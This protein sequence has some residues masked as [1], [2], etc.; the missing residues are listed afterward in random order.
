MHSKHH[1]TQG[2]KIA[3]VF[4]CSRVSRFGW[5]VRSAWQGLAGLSQLLTHASAGT[6]WVSWYLAGLPPSRRLARARPCPR[7]DS[8]GPAGKVEA[9]KA[10]LRGGT[11]SLLPYSFGA[12][13]GQNGRCPGPDLGKPAA[14]PPSAGALRCGVRGLT[15]GLSRWR[16]CVW[17]L[18]MAPAAAPACQ[19]CPPGCQTY[20]G[21]LLGPSRLGH[22]LA[23]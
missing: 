2:L 9:F 14:S 20:E 7:A 3:T 1:K 21:S 16:S 17:V 8:R 22:P 18:C 4:Y 23:K 12:K 19:P 11:R 15:A 6:R 5:V 13:Q 10:R